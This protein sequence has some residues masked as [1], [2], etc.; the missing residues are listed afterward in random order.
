MTLRMSNS[1]H[2]LAARWITLQQ[3]ATGRKEVPALVILKAKGE[4]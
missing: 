4:I 1:A 2:R 3:T